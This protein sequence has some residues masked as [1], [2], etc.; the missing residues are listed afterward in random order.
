[1]AR[2]TRR[3]A[4]AARRADTLAER[5]ATRKL[6]SVPSPLQT[7]DVRSLG[8]QVGDLTKSPAANLLERPDGDQH[9]SL[10][11]RWPVHIHRPA[12]RLPKHPTSIGQLAA[13]TSSSTTTT[14][15]TMT[16]LESADLLVWFPEYQLYILNSIEWGG[17]P[18]AR[19]FSA[20]LWR[21]GHVPQPDL[22]SDRWN[23]QLTVDL[24]ELHVDRAE[25]GD[26]KWILD[27]EDEPTP[28]NADAAMA[29]QGFWRASDSWQHAKDPGGR[30][31]YTAQFAQ[32]ADWNSGENA[33]YEPGLTVTVQPWDVAWQEF[34]M[35]KGLLCAAP[36]DFEPPQGLW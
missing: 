10:L 2:R 19:A 8:E 5:R 3:P 24:A 9:L 22:P 26:E 21:L 7:A 36:S 35:A 14:A 11:Q 17:D 18:R 16:G 23:A 29:E 28:D 27:L 15:E 1:M 12:Y 30:I 34:A 20:A 13:A 6:R 33:G 31:T 32:A 4:R 25:T